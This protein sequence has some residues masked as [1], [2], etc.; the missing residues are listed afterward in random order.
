M[1]KQ[2]F[3]YQNYFVNKAKMIKARRAT[4][5]SDRDNV[6]LTRAC[7]GG[8]LGTMPLATICAGI[9]IL[10]NELIKRGKPIRDFDHKEKAVEQI[11]ILGGEIYFLAK[12]REGYEESKEER[13]SI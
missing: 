11:Q 13:E 6:S 12:E 1:S 9:Q 10:M 5:Q 7:A 4:A 2:K 3:D 8:D